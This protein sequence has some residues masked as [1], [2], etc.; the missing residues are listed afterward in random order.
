MKFIVLITLVTI[1]LINAYSNNVLK[2]RRSI[3]NM[4]NL[5][6]DN[7]GYIIKVAIIIMHN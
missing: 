5:Q 2:V 3:V 1:A 7:Q 6:Y 4:S